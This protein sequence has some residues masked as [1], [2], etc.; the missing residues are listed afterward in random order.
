[1][2]NEND[3]KIDYII[4]NL[5]D[6]H[7]YWLLGV[8]LNGGNN[9]FIHLFRLERIYID[10]PHH[11][12]YSINTVCNYYPKLNAKLGIERLISTDSNLAI[13]EPI[14]YIIEGIYLSILLLNYE[15]ILT[16]NYQY[17]TQINR[18]VEKFNHKMI[19]PVC[20]EWFKNNK[21]RFPLIDFNNSNRLIT[22]KGEDFFSEYLETWH[23]NIN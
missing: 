1:M 17:G 21:F 10:I 2:D 14:R 8:T 18:I 4:E 11:P 19:C 9:P 12:S 20:I 3:N 22:S 13:Q 15:K 23:R 16:Y 5:D 6:V 7:L